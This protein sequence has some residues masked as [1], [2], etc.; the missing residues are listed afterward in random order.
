MIGDRY[1]I[2]PFP[3]ACPSAMSL[4]KESPILPSNLIYE[5]LCYPDKWTDGTILQL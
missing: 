5:T 4:G 1:S 2:L 3:R